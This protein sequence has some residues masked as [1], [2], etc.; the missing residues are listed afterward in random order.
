MKK[1]VKTTVGG[2]L[3]ALAG[4]VFAFYAL[5]YGGQLFFGRGFAYVEWIFAL[6]ALLLGLAGGVAA[7]VFLAAR[8]PVVF[9]VTI[10]P[11]AT[12]AVL[13]LVLGAVDKPHQYPIHVLGPPNTGFTGFID[14]DG[15][16]SELEGVTP[17]THEFKAS[18]TE[19]A[20]AVEDQSQP[21]EIS[22]NIHDGNKLIDA[23]P[24]VKGEYAI[25]RSF[26]YSPFFGGTNR[27]W[28]RLDETEIDELLR[29]GR[30]KPKFRLGPDDMQTDAAER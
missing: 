24:N 15:V 25:L 16:F 3:G 30:V 8:R 21:I 5:H 27:S 11:L 29:T 20:V 9:S 17:F 28:S 2:F 14:T 6:P 22:V 12:W 19:Y 26:G 10:L 7:G 4:S 13:T 18:R 23:G 1:I